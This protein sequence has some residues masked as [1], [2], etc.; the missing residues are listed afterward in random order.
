[1]AASLAASSTV[2]SLP[3]L[4]WLPLM[5]KLITFIL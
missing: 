3:T 4:T 2:L 1:M 5:V